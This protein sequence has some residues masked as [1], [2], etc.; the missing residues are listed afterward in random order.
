MAHT[1]TIQEIA[2]YATE[3]TV[4]QLALFLAESF[5]QG[6]V[7]DIDDSSVIISNDNFELQQQAKVKDAKLSHQGAFYAPELY[8]S[9]QGQINKEKAC[10]WSLGA[11]MF[12][13][14]MGMDVFEGM[15]GQSQNS[16]TQ[17]S[18][19]GSVHASQALSTLVFK[20]LSF[21]P[22]DRPTMHDIILTAQ[23][24]LEIAITPQK[25]LTTSSGKTY[26]ASL[27]SFWPDEMYAVLL[28][29]LLT[30]IPVYKTKAQTA[31]VIP[32]KLTDLVSLCIDL[33]NKTNNTKVTQE[34]DDDLSW[35]LMDELEVDRKGEC[36]INDDVQTLGINDIGDRILKYRGGVT[37][38]G[39]RF[40]NGQ[41]KRYNYSFIEVT[42][43]KG[44]S[45]K[46]E[47]TGR[48]GVQFFAVVPYSNQTSYSPTLTLGGKPLGTMSKGDN[49]VTYFR[50]ERPVELKDKMYLKIDN[51]SGANASFVILNY[52]SRQNQLPR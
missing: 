35:T 48:E 21:N 52:N 43:R 18:R 40:R 3:R 39:G 44:A 19:I 42:A 6:L 2:G 16:S 10:V 4:W 27:M 32:S 29:I 28:A 13:T 5:E 34:L 14:L 24:Q 41:D 12:K 33:R 7:A 20:C 47:I 46:Y 49:G 31:A 26:T 38:T 30:I 9:S 51:K 36:T 17:I 1:I 23:Q 11:L 15:G 50:V 45:V 8:A 37:N 22:S 25:R